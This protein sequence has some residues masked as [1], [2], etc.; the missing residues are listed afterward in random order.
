[1]RA[2]THI[3]TNTY[4][5]VSEHTHNRIA[6]TDIGQELV[7]QTQA[8]AG[9]LNDSC[10][11]YKLHSSRHNLLRAADLG[12]CACICMYLNFYTMFACVFCAYLF[13]GI[14]WM[15]VHV[16]FVCFT[17]VCM[18]VLLH[19]LACLVAVVV[20]EKVLCMQFVLKVKESM[21]YGHPDAHRAQEQC[22]C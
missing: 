11:V 9:P 3:R 1:M 7:A 4:I 5:H 14:S 2:H 19:L 12:H 21:T 20:I 15:C 8:L 6:F 10:N 18:W 13:V 22:L 16:L 17:C